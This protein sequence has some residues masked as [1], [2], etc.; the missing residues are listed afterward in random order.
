MLNVPQQ[1]DTTALEIVLIG[2]ITGDL[3]GLTYLIFLS[4]G[5]LRVL[6]KYAKHRDKMAIAFPKASAETGDML[7][8]VP[9]LMFI[10]RSMGQRG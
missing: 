7:H 1:E 5:C 3:D 6:L 9:L 10:H 8:R 4:L 2:L